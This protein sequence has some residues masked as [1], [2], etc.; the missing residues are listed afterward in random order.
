MIVILTTHRY[1]PGVR[2]SVPGQF[3]NL[4]FIDEDAA[5]D[6]AR[7]LAR[8]EGIAIQRKEIRLSLPSEVS[9]V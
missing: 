4:P 7:T 2:L 3:G 5:L 9:R 1:R 8:G 6:H